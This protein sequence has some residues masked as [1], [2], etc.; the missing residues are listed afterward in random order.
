MGGRAL[1]LPVELGDALNRVGPQR[2]GVVGDPA[3]AAAFLV[4]HACIQRGNQLAQL[5]DEK[6]EL[7]WRL[8][9][10]GGHVAR[11]YATDPRRA[12]PE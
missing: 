3:L 6:L 7:V 5:L 2:R 4:R 10:F 12:V 11:H 9:P 1:S 8:G